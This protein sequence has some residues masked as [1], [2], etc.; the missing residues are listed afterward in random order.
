VVKN[1]GAAGE[2]RLEIIT[3]VFTEDMVRVFT[4]DMVQAISESGTLVGFGGYRTGSGTEWLKGP[5]LCLC[6]GTTFEEKSFF[7]QEKR[8]YRDFILMS[9]IVRIGFFMH[10]SAIISALSKKCTNADLYH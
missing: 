8:G 10:I 6:I 2:G 4:E 5:I 1:A 9:C 7:V 3:R